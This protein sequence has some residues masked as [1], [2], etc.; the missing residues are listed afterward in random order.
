VSGTTGFRAN[1][2][3]ALVGGSYKGTT[4]NGIIG[5]P[6]LI[7]LYNYASGRGAS[8]RFQIS[9][10]VIARV[11]SADMTGSN[12]GIVVQPLGPDEDPNRVRLVE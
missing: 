8:A 9:R 2:E 3:V 11:V 7:A 12:K 10:F 5:E 4:Y 6:R 1:T